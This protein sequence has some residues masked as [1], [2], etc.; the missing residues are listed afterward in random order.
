[1]EVTCAKC[2]QEL[3]PK[4]LTCWAC[5]ALTAAG[6]QA[7]G[8]SADEEEVWRHS[9]AAAKVRHS[10]PAPVDP[11]EVLR[12]VVAESGTEE[13]LQRLTRGDLAYDDQRT[14]YPSLREAAH[15]VRLLGTLLAV[16]FALVSLLLLV[17]VIVFG[18]G[19]EGGVLLGN[20]AVAVLAGTLAL[21][22]YSMF[23]YLAEAVKAFADLADDGHRTVLLLRRLLAELPKR[24]EGSHE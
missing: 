16:P 21:A 23:K 6:R 4:A 10:Q 20:I 22:V 1:M 13:Q 12:R 17:A 19:S 3:D 15:G 7:K 8:L 14:E 5:G 9:V 2:G 18:K 11:D 24:N